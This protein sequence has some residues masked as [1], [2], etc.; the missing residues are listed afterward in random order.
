M[1]CIYTVKVDSPD[2]FIQMGWVPPIMAE[3][4][5]AAR[6]MSWHSQSGAEHLESLWSSVHTGMSKSWILTPAEDGESTRRAGKQHC[7]FTWT[8][9]IW[10]AC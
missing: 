3:N 8:T 1:E 6:K 5:V 4:P 10:A 7:L 2:W 9:C